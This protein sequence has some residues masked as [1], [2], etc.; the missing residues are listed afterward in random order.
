MICATEHKSAAPLTPTDAAVSPWHLHNTKIHMQLCASFKKQKQSKDKYKIFLLTRFL[1]III[2]PNI[3][4][5]FK[6]VLNVL[7]CSI[8]QCLEQSLNQDRK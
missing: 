6:T 8:I 4:R 3:I 2:N 5:L 1:V 7:F